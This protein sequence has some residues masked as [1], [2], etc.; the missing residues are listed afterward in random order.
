MHMSMSSF[1]RVDAGVLGS[2][3]VM[4]DLTPENGWISAVQDIYLEKIWGQ[5]TDIYQHLPS[6]HL[7]PFYL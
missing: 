6:R 1:L 3:R 5:N 2:K 7:A 4:K